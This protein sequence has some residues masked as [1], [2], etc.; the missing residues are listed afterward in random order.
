MPPDP[1]MG[2]VVPPVLPEPPSP[3]SPPVVDPDVPP[4]SPPLL[5]PPVDGS[6]PVVEP[7]LSEPEVDVSPPFVIVVPEFPPEGAPPSPPSSSRCGGSVNSVVS[8]EHDG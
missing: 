3:A 6:P 8:F 2:P 5:E 4:S 7:P 1:D